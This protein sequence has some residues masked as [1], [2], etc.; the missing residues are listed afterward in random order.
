MDR[1]IELIQSSFSFS[2][3]AMKYMVE[4]RVESSNA[5][6]L[7]TISSA[8]LT[9][10]HPPTETTPRGADRRLTEAGSLNHNSLPCFKMNQRRRQV[11]M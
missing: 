4:S 8:P 1:P 3:S 2:V 7:L 9:V 10:R 6:A 5:K 11:L